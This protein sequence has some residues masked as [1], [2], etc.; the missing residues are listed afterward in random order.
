LSTDTHDLI[1]KLSGE[2]KPVRPLPRAGLR[3][4]ILSLWA[5]ALS[6]GILRYTHD[7]RADL[8]DAV[9]HK[10]YMLDGITILAAGIL[11]SYAAFVLA[12]P[13]TR[14]RTP[15]RVCL[16]LASALWLELILRELLGTKGMPDPAPSCFIGL[17]MGMS[18]P[19]VLGMFMLMRSAAVWRGWAGYALVLS[20]GSF[21]ALAMRF[22]C[23]N[24]SAGHLLVW[25]FLPVIGFALLGVLVGKIL[26]N[27]RIAKK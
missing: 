1:E 9:Y 8:G 13:D 15:V 23:P 25:H 24:D 5:V 14:I 20:V 26:L 16:G 6:F 3:A 21:S 7:P 11:A 12:V 19:F 4:L 18:A 2:L 17:S 22:I 27:F 10:E